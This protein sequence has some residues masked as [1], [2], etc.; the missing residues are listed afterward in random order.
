MSKT[1]LIILFSASIF[2]CM[3][4]LIANAQIVLKKDD[5]TLQEALVSLAKDE[6]LKLVNNLDEKLG[7]QQ[8]KQVISGDAIDILDELSEIYDFEWHI[9]GGNM[10]VQSGQ[11]FINYTFRPKNI[12]PGMLLTELQDAILTSGTIKMQLIERG[13][14]LI[15]S[16]P[17]SFINDA[18]SYSNMVD[19]NEFLQNG[20]DLEIVRIEFDYLSVL[21]RQVNT[22]DGS[23]NFPGAGSLISGAL[24]NMGQFENIA[25]G[26]VLEKAY[27]VKLSDSSKQKLEEEEQTSKVQML[28]GTNALLVRGT[29]SEITLAKRIATMIDVQGK[30]LMFSLKVYDVAVERTE[31]FG[32]DGSLLNNSIGLY[33]ILSKPFSATKDFIKS[34][35]AM[36]RNGTARSIYSTNLLI[37]ENHQGH[38]GKKDTVTVNLVSSKEIE[39][40]KIEAD[41]SLYVT[42]KILPNGGVH[43]KLE[44]IEEHF[45]DGDGNSDVVQP[46]KV[47]SQSLSSEA[48]I[49]PHQTLVLGG[50]DNTETQSSES[51]I[52]VLSSI[53]FVGEI[54]KSTTETK[55]KYKRYIAVS[56]EVID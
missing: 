12:T 24:S 27:K 25:D 4:S 23:V 53:P 42:G 35:Q 50:F 33:D 36:Y 32:A 6:Q 19:S 3:W 11:P 41:N 10:S 18:I 8:I 13:N 22:F 34:F 46:P 16:G 48:Y 20:N 45:D 54:F 2:L 26:Q 37:L 52:P 47:S 21:D 43:A 31:G 5:M 51:G 49:K 28:P 40:L 39:S 44:Y 14:S 30:Q 17:R 7:R 55:R 15:Y 29:P 1:K 38:F 56:F 9:Y